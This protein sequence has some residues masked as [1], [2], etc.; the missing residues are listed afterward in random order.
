MSDQEFHSQAEAIVEAIL[1]KLKTKFGAE[2][3]FVS[4]KLEGEVANYSFTAFG[5]AA[6]IQVQLLQAGKVISEFNLQEETAHDAPKRFLKIPDL[7]INQQDIEQLKA[8]ATE[9]EVKLGLLSI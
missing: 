8:A 2:D 4:Q 5:D 6:S 1:D 7:N 9:I 3:H